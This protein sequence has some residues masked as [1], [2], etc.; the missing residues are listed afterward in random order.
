MGGKFIGNLNL[1][2]E[3]RIKF[4]YQSTLTLNITIFE[5]ST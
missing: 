2:E 5:I 3:M 1:I 4:E